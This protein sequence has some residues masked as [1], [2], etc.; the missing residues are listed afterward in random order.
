[1]GSESPAKDL[2][3]NMFEK[4]FGQKL[5]FSFDEIGSELEMSRSDLIQRFRTSEDFIDKSGLNDKLSLVKRC[6]HIFEESDRVRE[7]KF[8]CETSQDPKRLGEL[9]TESHVSLRDN[10]ECSHPALDKLVQV[11]LDAGAFGARLTG[12]GWGGCIVSL[13]GPEKAESVMQKLKE[14][15]KFTFRTE[16][17]SGAS[18]IKIM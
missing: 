6:R 11:A 18:I 13:V 17:Q 16:P 14:V 10:Y 12:A 15:S 1:M 2:I 8:I 9:M 4:V 5:E 7:F 3:S